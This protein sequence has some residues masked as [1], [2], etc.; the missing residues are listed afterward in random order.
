[1]E[2]HKDIGIDKSRDASSTGGIDHSVGALTR[3]SDRESGRDSGRVRDVVLTEVPAD[4]DGF[5]FKSVAQTLIARSR[6]ITVVLLIFILLGVGAAVGYVFVVSSHSGVA[7]TMIAFTFPRAEEGL[8]PHGQPLDVYSIR[9]PYV[10]ANA[11]ES[12]ELRDRVTVNAVR[13]NMRIGAVTSH[14]A[15]EEILQIRDSAARL[16][17]R[18]IYVGEVPNYPTEYVVYLYRGGALSDLEDQEISDLLDAIIRSY[19][20]FFVE[21]YHP[22]RLMELTLNTFDP[23]EYDY[24]EIVR[25]FNIAANN[26]LSTVAR[27][28]NAA[29]N[30]RSPTTQ[31]TFGDIG[32]QVD[33]LRMLD[34]TRVGAVVNA[35]NMSRNRQRMISIMEYNLA[36]M[37]RDMGWARANAADL[38][39]LV[40]LYELEQWFFTQA[41]NYRDLDRM[42]HFRSSELYDYMFNEIMYYMIMANTLE[43]DI[44][45]YRR[46]LESMRAAQTPAD[47]RDILFVEGVIPQILDALQHWETMIT[48]TTE[49]FIALEVYR[50]GVQVLRP[51]IFRSTLNAHFRQ[52]AMIVAASIVVGLFVGVLVAL[53]Q[54]EVRDRR[55]MA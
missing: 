8:N 31:L 42:T 51:A 43:A 7:S 16:P 22:F 28:S 27:F 36:R 21:T 11:L 47:P 35:S 12:T 52:M 48:Q 18:L 54:G 45:F 41:F 23:D 5:S 44:A 49:D 39:L 19:V 20:D 13:Q 50:E 6:M 9:S 14:A 34:I 40:E 2:E 32:A 17:E 37:E 10:I 15:L 25:V 24:M 38:M 4:D 46:Q 1:M 3:D 26:M 53:Y 29:P 33:L 55:K 30:F